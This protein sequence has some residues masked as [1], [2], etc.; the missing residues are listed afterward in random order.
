MILLSLSPDPRT[1]L[2]DLLEIAK[3]DHRISTDERKLIDQIARDIKK[4]EQAVVAALEDNIL[5]DKE[6]LILNKLHKRVIENAKKVVDA[7]NVINS[8]ERMILDRLIS[9][10]NK[11]VIK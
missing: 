5:T 2:Q 11:V 7:D 3:A 10:L 6:I 4:Y 9:Y 8:E 1:L